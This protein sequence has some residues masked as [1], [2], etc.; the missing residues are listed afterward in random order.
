MLAAVAHKLYHSFYDDFIETDFIIIGLLFPLIGTRFYLKYSESIK[1]QDI[2][3]EMRDLSDN[4]NNIPLKSAINNFSKLKND[5]SFFIP[6]FRIFNWISA[7]ILTN[8]D[9]KGFLE[10]VLRSE[11][12]IVTGNTQTSKE[13]GENEQKH[14]VDGFL[15]G[16]VLLM[17]IDVLATFQQESSLVK[18]VSFLIRQLNRLK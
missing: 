7:T 18:Q 4:I 2:Q 15:L 12:K 9:I 17:V 10:G 3:N 11:K 14:M 6:C 16:I 8:K 13:S 5:I 1:R